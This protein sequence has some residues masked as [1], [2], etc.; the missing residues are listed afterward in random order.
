MALE[1][2]ATVV[3]YGDLHRAAAGIRRLAQSGFDLAQ[4]SMMAEAVRGGNRTSSCYYNGR[5]MRYWG[6]L[7]AFWGPL[8][9]LL[10]GWALFAMPAKGPVLVAGPLAG[11][12]F[13]ILG[14]A[15]VFGGLTAVGAG[16]YNLGI[17]KES[18]R[19]CE[20]AM[21]SGSYLL[22]VHGCSEEVCRAR[23]I[24][25]TTGAQGAACVAWADD[26]MPAA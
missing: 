7:G 19:Q 9:G 12:M 11:W 23:R 6:N 21:Q 25:G 20:T 13:E 18:V 10:S 8:W 26:P 4:V 14:D 22:V 2:N 15:T 1:E 5:E 3:V 17:P 24:L 16:L